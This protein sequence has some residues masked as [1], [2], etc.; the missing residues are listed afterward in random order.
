MRKS[1]LDVPGPVFAALPSDVSLFGPFAGCFTCKGSEKLY[2]SAS[3]GHWERQSKQATH[4]SV[5]TVRESMS[6][7]PALHTFSHRLQAVHFSASIVMAKRENRAGRERSAPT[8]QTVLQYSLPLIIDITVTITKPPKETI[9][10]EAE[11][12]WI[13]MYESQ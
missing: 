11:T 4:L 9:S 13:L 12:A 5:K 3:K 2:E 8:G 1:R 7:Q 10:S 6:M